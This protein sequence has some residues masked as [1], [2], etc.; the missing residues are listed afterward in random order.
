M[1]QPILPA[2]PAARAGVVQ[3]AFLGGRPRVPVGAWRPGQ[4][5]AFQLK[6]AMPLGNAMPLPDNFAGVRSYSPART[7]PQAIQARMESLF[8]TSF[9]D[10]RIHEGPEASSIG[11]LAFTRGSSIFFAPG[12]YNPNTSQ[13][14]RLLGQQLAHVVQQRSGRVRNPFGSG[15]AVV[16]DPLLK[17]EAEMMGARA[18]MPQAVQP[19]SLGDGVQGAHSAAGSW[20]QTP[21]PILPKKAGTVATPASAG[22]GAILPSAPAPILPKRADVGISAI[23][24]SQS[25]P[26]GTHGGPI[27]PSKPVQAKLAPAPILPGHP[28]STPVAAGLAV[29]QPVKA[30]GAAVVGRQ[31]LFNSVITQIGRRVFGF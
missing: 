27:L 8:R 9:R 16:N 12:Q 14:Q 13:G 7:L 15:M 17:A 23:L 11:A 18:A 2:R 31:K 20:Q 25:N 6:P 29:L 30:P 10:V 4:N 22:G 26:A 24:P 21:S 5:G 1:P 3:G 19:K 28:S